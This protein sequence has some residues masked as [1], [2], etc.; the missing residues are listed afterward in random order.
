MLHRVDGLAGRKTRLSR[1]GKAAESSVPPDQLHPHAG[2]ARL[3]ARV[4][5]DLVH[6]VA[7]SPGETQ[8]GGRPLAG[9]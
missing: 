8:S 5:D 7:V 3:A 2:D 4:A 9:R 1:L 6:Q